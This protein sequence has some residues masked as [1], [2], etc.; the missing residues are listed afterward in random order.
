MTGLLDFKVCADDMFR[1][2]I[3]ADRR[4]GYD[5]T[6]CGALRSADDIDRK[7]IVIQ[8]FDKLDHR[9][10]EVVDVSHI[11]ETGG[12]L[13]AEF[14]RVVVVFLNRHAGICLRKVA[15]KRLICHIARLDFRGNCLQLIR[16]TLRMIMETVFNEHHR[17]IVGV[18]CLACQGAVHIEY[19]NT[20]CDRDIVRTVFIGDRSHIIDQLL[21]RCGAF[22]PEGKHLRGRFCFGGFF[23]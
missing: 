23:R 14:H 1:R 11:V 20:V 8:I 15:G 17:V 5:C 13:F 22:R 6:G 9:E 7:L 2:D 3:F 21:F 4:V 18:I 19:R 10:I 12:L 16:D